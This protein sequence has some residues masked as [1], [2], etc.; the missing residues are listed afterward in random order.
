MGI[1]GGSDDDNALVGQTAPDITLNDQDGNSVSLSDYRGKSAVVVYFYPKDDTPGCTVESCT[2]RDQYEDFKEAGAE[3]IGISQDTEGSHRAFADKHRLPFTLL[4]DPGGG[5]RKAFRV[6]KS[7]GLLP[8]RVTYLVDKQGT[9][10]H[11]FSSQLNV[12]KH[13]TDALEVLR[14][15]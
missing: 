12:R 13:V 11:V 3:V 15:L 6:P 9:V 4:A 2:F 14:S 1:F 10:R 8:G 7:M 5:A